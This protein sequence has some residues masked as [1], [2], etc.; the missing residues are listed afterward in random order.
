MTAVPPPPLA[1][2]TSGECV[3]SEIEL[4]EFASDAENAIGSAK[5]IDLI[6]IIPTVCL[7]ILA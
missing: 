7:L 6:I 5:K 3:G 1:M 2:P 4:P